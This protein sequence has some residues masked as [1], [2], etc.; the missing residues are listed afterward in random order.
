MGL[1]A[2]RSQISLPHRLFPFPFP[3]SP[4]PPPQ[5]QRLTP[6]LLLR[7]HSLPQALPQQQG[8][9]LL[10]L[11]I[12]GILRWL[13]CGLIDVG[14]RANRGSWERSQSRHEAQLWSIMILFKE[15]KREV[16]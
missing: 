7:S 8:V 4:I 9:P 15:E 1:A 16:I 14:S 6:R 10:L 11:L 12:E 3:H 13:W 5:R 2:G